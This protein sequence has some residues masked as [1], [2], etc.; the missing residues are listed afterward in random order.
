MPYTAQIGGALNVEGSFNDFFIKQITAKGLPAFIP[1]SVVNTDYP[2][3]PL[4]YPSF[5][6]I[7]LG[8][9]PQQIAEGQNLDDGWRGVRQNGLA[10][11]DCW[12]SYQRASG[13]HI[14]NI[15]IMRDMAAR[16]FATGAA[17]PILDVYGS[18]AAPTSNG[19][20]IR[21]MAAQSFPVAP[22]PN[23]DVVRARL[24]VEYNWLER[25]TAG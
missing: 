5:S 20:I 1:S 17:I 7:H 14:Y 2:V 23:P 13:N 18:T 25:V 3:V 4:T 22:D 16:V 8:S 15:R 11:I 9:T 24:V 21:A 19:T 6:I 10:E 12:E